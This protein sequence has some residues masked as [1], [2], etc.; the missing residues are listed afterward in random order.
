MWDKINDTTIKI[1]AYTLLPI[2]Y[3]I[4]VYQ[5][6]KLDEKIKKEFIEREQIKQKN[7]LR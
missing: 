1:I 5:M 4:H 7:L 2:T 3:P 6:K